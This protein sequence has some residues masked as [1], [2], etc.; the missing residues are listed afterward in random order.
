MY[1][2]DG[3]LGQ[4]ARLAAMVPDDV[5]LGFHLCYGDAPLG[6]D[7]TGQHFV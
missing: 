5:T 2:A 6:P 3:L 7:G 4:V 1:D